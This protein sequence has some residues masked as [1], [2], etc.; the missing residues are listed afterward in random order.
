MRRGA[1][2][3]LLAAGIAGC[4]AL[5]LEPVFS[6]SAFIDSD[7]EP[8]RSGILE[9]GW[10]RRLV[11]VEEIDSLAVRFGAPTHGSSLGLVFVGSEDS[12][13]YALRDTDGA[14]QWRFQALGRVDG[15]PAIVEDELYFGCMDGALYSVNARTG[16]LRWRHGTP[17]EIRRPP[18]VVG[19]AVCF[20]NGDDTVACVSRADGHR[21]WRYRRTPPGGITGSGHAGLL[22]SGTRIYTG[23]S[24]GTVAALDARDGSLIWQQETSAD[25]ENL[26]ERNEAHEAIDVDTTPVLVG[27]TIYAA[28]FA[29]GLYAFDVTSGNRR[30][31]RDDLLHVAGL[32]AV[33]DDVF[34]ASANDGIMRIDGHDGTTI[35]RRQIEEAPVVNVSA[36]GP[37]L[38]GVMVAR[39]GLWIVRA[40]DGQPLDALRPGLDIAPSMTS[41]DGRLF[42]ASAG[43]SVYFLRVRQ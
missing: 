27:D 32:A 13:L 21:R 11:G 36:V 8:R 12:G 5:R 31:R 2:A 19:D 30:W 28:S 23:F 26:D 17:A 35:W 14:V 42:A 40:H 1:L 29:A 39:R 37:G 34:A 10:T 7:P 3:C 18:V 41:S 33:G 38:L 22:L 4:S 24:D 16:S 9:V 6:D 25:I 20:V 43:G 15:T